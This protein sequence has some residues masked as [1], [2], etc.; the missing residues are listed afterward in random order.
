MK[1]I[2]L[3][4]AALGMIGCSSGGG[5]G[6]EGQSCGSKDLF[7]AWGGQHSTLGLN[8]T[9]LGFGTN[10]FDRVYYSTGSVFTCRF[11]ANIVGDQCSGY[12]EVTSGVH[13]EASPSN[14]VTYCGQRVGR[15][16]YQKTDQ[17]LIIDNSF[18]LQ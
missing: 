9:G 5:S 3:I 16:N 17:G 1:T 10:T 7:S 13:L 11:T 12:Y 4:I 2:L 18:M 6:A 15:I 8:L 14:L